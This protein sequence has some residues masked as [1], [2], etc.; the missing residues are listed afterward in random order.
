M[1]RTPTSPLTLPGPLNHALNLYGGSG[2]VA[3]ACQ[4]WAVLWLSLKNNRPEDRVEVATGGSASHPT[5]SPEVTSRTWCS[6]VTRLC[7]DLVSVS[8]SKVLILK[9]SASPVWLPCEG[10]GVRPL[11]LRV[12]WEV[13]RGAA[14]TY[15]V[16]EI[17][18]FEDQ[19]TEDWQP[20]AGKQACDG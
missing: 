6:S 20:L 18:N 3:K 14:L 8:F 15:I 7:W 5:G 2:V 19:L 4:G 1:S 13:G 12:W 17:P 10:Q 9:P 11:T 16:E